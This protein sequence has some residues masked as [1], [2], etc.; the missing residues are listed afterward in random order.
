MRSIILL[1]FLSFCM[2]FD[3][4]NAQLKKDTFI[5]FSILVYN[6][7]TSMVLYGVK[8]ARRYNHPFQ[9]NGLKFKILDHFIEI[10]R[11]IPKWLYFFMNV[12]NMFIS[13]L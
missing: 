13:R 4:E 8:S 5:K 6:T 1:N 10:S 2:C 12:N 9:N 11:T 7:I 3:I